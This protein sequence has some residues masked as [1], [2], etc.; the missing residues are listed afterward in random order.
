MLLQITREKALKVKQTVWQK[1]KKVQSNAETHPPRTAHEIGSYCYRECFKLRCSR[2]QNTESTEARQ[3]FVISL[4]PVIKQSTSIITKFLQN[5]SQPLQV[6][7]FYYFLPS[8]ALVYHHYIP[9]ISDTHEIK[10][11]CASLCI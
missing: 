9:L 5:Q 6:P 8:D 2:A 11:V 7:P 4:Y 1:K 10:L 3:P